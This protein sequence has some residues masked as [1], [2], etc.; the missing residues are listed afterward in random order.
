MSTQMIAI[1]NS[2]QPERTEPFP[3]RRA[4]EIIQK[5][6][7]DHVTVLGGAR[8]VYD[9]RANLFVAADIPSGEYAVHMGLNANRGHFVVKLKK[10][11]MIDPTDILNLTRKGGFTPHTSSMAVNLV[12][13]IVRQEANLRH[14]FL[15]DARSFYV[16]TGERE[17][18]RGLKAWRGF[19]QSVR[20]V[21]GRLLINVDT[22]TA[23]VY[24]D[25]PL[26]ALAMKY[27]D[28]H[29][30]RE[31][32]NLKSSNMRK[33]EQF[34]KGVLVVVTQPQRS[35]AQRRA[36]AISG[37]VPQAGEY[38]FEKDGVTTTV[39]NH[40]LQQ[41]NYRV[42]NPNLFGVRIGKTAVF[43]AE[44]CNVVE[45]QIYRKKLSVSQQTAFIKFAT[46]APAD[47]LKA[48]GDATKGD[49]LDYKVSLSM[50]EAGMEISTSPIQVNG[51][52]LES[53]PIEYGRNETVTINKKTGS[54]NIVRKQFF[55]PEAIRCWAVACFENVPPHVVETFVSKLYANLTK[56][57]THVHLSS[58]PIEYGNPAEVKKTLER[59]GELALQ[60]S[61]VQ[62]KKVDFILVILP[63]NAAEVRAQVKYWGD[64][65]RGVSTQC[66]RVGKFETAG[67]QYC[68]NVAL[69]I[70]AK[71]GG[72]NSVFVSP[73]AK[74]F[75]AST[76]VVGADVSHPGPGIFN[77][78]SIASLVASMTPSMSVYRSQ[79]R[80]QEPRHEIIKDLENM[81]LVA[82]QEWYNFR[83]RSQLPKTILF[84]RDGVSEGE[85]EK[86]F[87]EEIGYI[88]NA[89]N[90]AIE[91]IMHAATRSGIQRSAPDNPQLIFIVVGKRH[92]IRFFPQNPHD[93]DKS[94][95]CPTGFVVEDQVTNT[96]LFSEHYKDFYLQ[97]HSGIIG[98]SRPAHY[99][100]LQNETSLGLQHLQQVSYLLCHVYASA[101]RAVSI[102]APVY[103]A[104]RVCSRAAYHFHPDQNL[105]L[106]EN[107][108]SS[109]DASREFDLAKWKSAFKESALSRQLYFL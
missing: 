48:I 83:K 6:Q 108:S 1:T 30:L 100:V 70:N 92:H 93:S 88:R 28:I 39:K 89:L 61:N 78:P 64:V 99:I 59:A 4:H 20:P 68:N 87:N 38:R 109:S 54:W 75:L 50:Q 95:N 97:S 27:L 82:L 90:T 67:D 49:A 14:G 77:R 86:V 103:Y 42:R 104:D 9:G 57:G 79:M 101:T 44:V 63:Q 36:R 8:V 46:Q 32:E 98:T 5:L 37:L 31:L 47:K 16:R 96:E 105:H 52:L 51:R 73:D 33:L 26:T 10:T 69:K 7:T 65:F 43:P 29:N 41:H 58:P 2:A 74:Q 62:P 19:F 24:N 18:D 56:L 91:G 66:V 55:A 107:S 76:M 21:L 12:Q 35:S 60:N 15:A 85:F 25:G 81:M 80:L 3:P 13:L 94:G 102:P 72:I 71:I 45:G 22:S 53:P 17:L 84:Y 23:A 40:F 34:L 106:E 11:A